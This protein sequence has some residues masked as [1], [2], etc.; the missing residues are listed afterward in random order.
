M[1]HS[2]LPELNCA[3]HDTLWFIG[4]QSHGHSVVPTFQTAEEEQAFSISTLYAGHKD[5]KG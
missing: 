4:G 2:I 1:A 5:C 3:M